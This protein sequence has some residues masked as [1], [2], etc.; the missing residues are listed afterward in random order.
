MS[1]LSAHDLTKSYGAV[2]IL[3]GVSVTLSRGERVGLVGN[4]GAGKSTLARILSGQEVADTGELMQER[5]SRVGY[6][7]QVPILDETLTARQTAAL[8]LLAWSRVKERYDELSER[9]STAPAEEADDLLREQEVNANELE[10]LGGWD[11]EHRIS[12]LLQHLQ[13]PNEN[14]L[15]GQLSGGEKRRVSLCQLLL[16]APDLMVL[17]EPTNHLDTETSDWLERYLL[18]Q[19]KGA[20]LLITHD[21]YF[22]DRLVNRTL[23]VHQGALISFDGGW[24][25]YLLAKAERA[26]L[27]SRTES[28]RQNFLRREIEWLRRQPKARGTKQKAR[29]QRAEEALGKGPSGGPKDLNLSVTSRRQ[30]H[31]ILEFDHVQ[32]RIG[33]RVLVKDLHLTMTRGQRIGIIGHNGC[34]KTTLLRAVTAE[35]KPTQGEV[36]VGKNTHAAYFDQNRSGLD[37]DATIAHNVA[38]LRD[39][40][41]FGDQQLTIY[42]YL[43]RFQFRGLD[44]KKPV[45]MLSG[46]ERAR[47]ALAKLLLTQTNLLLLDEPTNDLDVTTL[48]ALED[49]LIDFPGS[50]LVVTHD[51]YFLNRVATDI[52]AFEGNGEVV[53]YVGN[54]DTY[55]ALRPKPGYSENV[56]ARAPAAGVSGHAPSPSIGESGVPFRSRSTSGLGSSEGQ[57]GKK[58]SYKELRELEGLVLRI[59]ELE[60]ETSDLQAQL[61]NANLYRADP[62]QALAFQ[63]SLTAKNADLEVAMSRWEELETRRETAGQ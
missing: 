63:E 26:D 21:R 37:P 2:T 40:V 36:R 16:S 25:E 50:A 1:L 41:D 39:K 52:L 32:M 14:A 7:A 56:Q 6:L 10:R 44:L 60:A 15:I 42:S 17:D 34:G 13:V 9:L 3:N 23:E 33:D 54:Y 45:S 59:A 20:L 29:T 55:K 24:E 18:D 5:G 12:S 35:L 48:G 62:Q 11:Q 61:A 31:D 58:L 30:G 19:F 53:H 49:M 28:N 38:G 57:S 8:G 22:L 46:G 43:E 27:D 47:V 4:N 51:R